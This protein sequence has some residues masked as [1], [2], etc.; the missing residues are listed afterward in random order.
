MCF[1]TVICDLKHQLTDVELFASFG[2]DDACRDHITENSQI[3]NL[4]VEL[5][6]SSVEKVPQSIQT[7]TNFNDKLLYIFTSGTTGL[8]KAAVIKNSR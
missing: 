1:F 3:V 7:C 2:D 8:P 6:N 5:V 4:D